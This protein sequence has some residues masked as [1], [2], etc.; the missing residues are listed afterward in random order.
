MERE[1]QKE[2]F[3]AED[4]LLQPKHAE[5]VVSS[6]KL[7][8]GNEFIKSHLLLLL[9]DGWGELDYE[10]K[11]YQLER[12]H[13]YLLAPG[14]FMK[15]R[16]YEKM[17][18]LHYYKISFDLWTPLAQ[19]K[20]DEEGG[21]LFHQARL[22]EGCYGRLQAELTGEILELA[23]ELSS[24]CTHRHGRAMRHQSLLG[25]LLVRLLPPKYSDKV[26]NT[27]G[28]ERT[29]KYMQSRYD[30]AI[31]REKL[32]EMAGLSVWHFS[33][34][35][36]Q[37]TG[38]SPMEYLNGIRMKQAKEQLLT[39]GGAIRDIARQVGFSD[40]FYF[41]RKFKQ[42]VGLSP[43]DYA[44]Q[45]LAKIAVVS[46]PYT[47]H[48]LALGIAPYVA[49]VDKRRDVHR[50]EFMDHIPY[51]LS[52]SKTESA[53]E[54]EANFDLLAKA[55]PEV[56]IC[57]E[58]EEAASVGTIRQLAPTVVIEWNRLDWRSHFREVA[59][60]VGKR[61]EAELWL[62]QYEK[63]VERAGAFLRSKLGEETVSVLHIMLGELLVYGRRNAGAVLFEDLGLNPPYDVNSMHTYRIIEL[64][65]LASYAGDHLL[66][67]VDADPASMKTWEMVRTSATWNRLAA[68]KK[69]HV[70]MQ[71][72]MPWL[73]YSPFAHNMVIDQVVALFKGL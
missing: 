6:G 57:S 10:R 23:K 37:R 36:K 69:Y 4:W 42:S 54:W 65:E 40:E 24:S 32:A 66:L 19:I 25:D 70:Y 1:E 45:K 33:H 39:G 62:A 30:E 13:S 34:M 71:Y 31:T 58:Y 51:Q 9:T 35:F 72:E 41:S 64:E 38:T 56:I 48:L 5:L 59:R 28:L 14:S 47:G 43:S 29:I 26:K 3:W 46:F 8:E 63:K 2:A 21:A 53:A 49:V 68:V 12:G 67:I 17:N 61:R 55:R 22:G 18:P 27:S 16:T 44:K 52:R 15:M 7:V 60:V 11:T 73:D 20:P 50:T